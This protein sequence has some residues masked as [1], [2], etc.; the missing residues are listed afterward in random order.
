VPDGVSASVQHPI[1]LPGLQTEPEGEIWY[2]P[3]HPRIVFEEDQGI[4][5]RDLCQNGIYAVQVHA[6]IPLV[7]H[8]PAPG[9]TR[10]DANRGHRPVPANVDTAHLPVQTHLILS[11]PQIDCN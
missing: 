5:R 1:N 9:Q 11:V 10:A 2:F 3:R 8:I 4:R 7:W 6:S